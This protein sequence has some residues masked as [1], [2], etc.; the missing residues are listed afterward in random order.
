LRFAGIRPGSTRGDHRLEDYRSTGPRTADVLGHLT[1]LERIVRESYEFV[2]WKSQEG[3]IRQI[4][5][6]VVE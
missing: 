6:K 5:W 4:L 2:E 1:V 3:P